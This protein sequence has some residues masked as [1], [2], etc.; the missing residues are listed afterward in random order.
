MNN[1]KFDFLLEQELKAEL[2]QVGSKLEF[3]A[4]DMIVEPNKYI[5]VIP[6]LL[7]GSIKVIRETS[8]GNELILYYIKSG[9]SCAVSLSTSLMNKLSNIKAIA[10]EKVELIAVPASISVK[11]YENYPSWRMFVLRTMD[12]RY[13]E[14]ISALDSVAFKK[15]DERLVE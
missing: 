14:I 2:E 9:Q 7:R 4:G 8:E 10:E 3:K 12:N 1:R 5:K 13:E 15:V 6:L 11:W